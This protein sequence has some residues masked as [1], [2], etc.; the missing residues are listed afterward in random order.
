MAVFVEVGFQLRIGSKDP[1]LV[2]SKESFILISSQRESSIGTY[3]VE[4]V[5]PNNWITVN[6]F[7]G[8][9][10]NEWS[11][12]AKMAICGTKILDYIDRT[13]GNYGITQVSTDDPK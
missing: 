3:I 4:V 9:N 2:S 12:S 1:F 6:L 5:K 11:Y 7:H 10:I 13:W 8:K